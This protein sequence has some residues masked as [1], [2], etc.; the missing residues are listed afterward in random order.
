M[1][2]NSA[3]SRSEEKSKLA[4]SAWTFLTLSM[5]LPLGFVFCVFP[6]FFASTGDEAQLFFLLALLAVF[7]VPV[8]CCAG[9]AQLAS[10]KG[11][12]ANHGFLG[13]LWIVGMFLVLSLPDRWQESGPP[14]P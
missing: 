1:N 9:C 6:F 14:T 3:Q 2:P 5:A 7:A 12:S 10:S 13:L 11:Q 8:L 4:K